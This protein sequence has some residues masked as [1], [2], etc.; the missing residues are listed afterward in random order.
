MSRGEQLLS[1]KEKEWA[2]T[3]W[4]E[5]YTKLQIANAL[6]VC[7]KTVHR[8]FHGKPRI[9]PELVYDGE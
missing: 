8:A 7:E 3:K 1:N 6:H 4:C 2:Y 9:R 5:G